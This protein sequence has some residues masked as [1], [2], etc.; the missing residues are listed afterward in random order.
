MGYSLNLR[1]RDKAL[2]AALT[3]TLAGIGA[4]AYAQQLASAAP[5]AS[6]GDE[7]SL[8]EIVV[9][10]QRRAERSQD[11]PLTVV[12]VSSEDLAHSGVTSLLDIGSIVSGISYGGAGA[13]SQPAIR[14]V[15][16][17]LTAAGSENPNAVYV[18][19]IYSAVPQMFN[20]ELPDV[21]RIEVLKGP[22]GTLFGRNATGGAIQVFTRNPSFTP[23][24]DISVEGSYYTGDGGSKSDP[25]GKVAGFLTAP[26]IPGL[27]AASISGGYDYTKG[28]LTIDTPGTPDLGLIRK[29][30]ARGKLL[31]TPNDRIELLLSAYYI[32][33]NLTGDS[34]QSAYKGLSAA[35]GYPGATIA[36]GPWHAA[37]DIAPGA[38][39]NL[40]R[41]FGF[42]A[43]AGLT[44]DAGTITSLTGYADTLSR[45][46]QTSLTESNSPIPCLLA[47]ACLQ[48]TYTAPTRE[49]S[50]ELNFTSREFGIASFVGGLYYYHSD[51]RSL[52]LIQAGLAPL[53]P[54]FPLVATQSLFDTKAYSAYGEAHIKATDDLSF[55]L[56]IRENYEP[57]ED[58]AYNPDPIV[59]KKTFDSTTPR[60]SV[61]YDFTHDFNA[62]ATYSVGYKS[63]LTGATNN[64]TV[65]PFAPVAPEK[66]VA[67]E[68]GLKFASDDLTLNGAF[69]YYNYKNKQES[70][71]V[72]A[73][74]I[75]EN[76]GPVRIYGFD[77]DSRARL[78]NGFSLR[79]TLS[80]IP[81]AKYLDFPA[82]SGQ[83]PIQAPGGTFETV[84]FDATG[85]RL[86][87]TPT[88]TANTT[89][90]YERGLYDASAT[91]NYSSKVYHEITEFVTQNAYA[92]LS[93]RAGYMFSD[94]FRV[95]VFGRNLTNK[96]YITQG[97]FTSA[98]FGVGYAPPRELGVSLDYKF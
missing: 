20:S 68:T 6:S 9:T 8:A 16:T 65:P 46:P 71:L 28:F 11:V 37:S 38:G 63:G 86:I 7:G 56:G 49:F 76:T 67:Y 85:S 83:S 94:G 96:A 40:T 80:Y 39:E 30:N 45:N 44:L 91:V 21:D 43:K 61:K 74:T 42:S 36:T 62:Y 82:A 66:V 54:I 70:T 27:L 10:A 5:G 12:A 97:T 22:Q 33:N 29:S 95:G 92:T 89:L 55:I 81:V 15:S 31:F 58:V 57:H 18:D 88:V 19:G 64:G 17:T 2:L 25:R 1:F 52:G 90:L 47:F 84:S 78:G 26:I 24:G 73:V 53:A 3:V 60:V 50:Q 23:A 79:S 98:A 77:F 48:Y 59:I 13:T 41:Q 87:R 93:A 75:I 4:P 69:F 34:S 14:G 35:S 72:G 51:G 32:D